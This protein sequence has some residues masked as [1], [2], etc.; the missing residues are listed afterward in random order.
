MSELVIPWLAVG[1]MIA[2]G[3][4]MGHATKVQKV[5]KS[6]SRSGPPFYDCQGAQQ[7]RAQGFTG[8]KAA[9]KTDLT[10]FAKDKRMGSQ[11]AADAAAFVE[12]QSQIARMQAWRS[13]TNHSHEIIVQPNS[14]KPTYIHRW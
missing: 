12:Q 14:R 8:Y 11:D 13:A 1:S 9:L 3:Y 7:L 6:N 4:G 10:Q 5:Q 2:L